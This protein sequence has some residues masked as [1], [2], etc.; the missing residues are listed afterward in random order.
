MSNEILYR[1]PY[2]LVTIVSKTSGLN[3]WPDHGYACIL[4]EL[5]PQRGTRIQDCGDVIEFMVTWSDLRQMLRALAPH[6]EAMLPEHLTD[7]PAAKK[8]RWELINQE[9]REE[10]Q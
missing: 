10:N 3:R 9:R 4:Y 5:K 8:A 7:K 6:V 2:G 1:S